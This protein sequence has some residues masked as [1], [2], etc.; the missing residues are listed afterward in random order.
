MGEALPFDLPLDLA[1]AEAWLETATIRCL[2]LIDPGGGDLPPWSAGSHIDVRL[3][4][5]KSVV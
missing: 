3:P 2:R 4:D 1:V 5:R